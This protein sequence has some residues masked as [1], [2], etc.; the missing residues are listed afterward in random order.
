MRQL[1]IVTICALALAG[2]NTTSPQVETRVVAVP[3][4]RPYRYIKPHPVE[5]KLSENLLAQISRH[6]QVHWKVKEA[7]R[8][9]ENH[10][11]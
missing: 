3:S 7:E 10:E 9:A 1:Q 6:N 8:R 4:S 11:K 5:D 2:C